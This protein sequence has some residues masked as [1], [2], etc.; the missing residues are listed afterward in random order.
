MICTYIGPTHPTMADPVAS[1]GQDL[2]GR[3]DPRDC[4]A[5]RAMRVPPEKKEI[6][7]IRVKGENAAEP[8][9]LVTTVSPDP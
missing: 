3:Q 8:V 6:V 2:L 5:C 1:A 7:V 9:D 4:L